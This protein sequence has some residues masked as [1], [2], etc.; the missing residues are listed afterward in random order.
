M[1]VTD[2][3]VI[4]YFMLSAGDPPLSGLAKKVFAANPAVIVPSLWRHEYLNVL[5]KYV[6]GRRLDLSAA[7]SLWRAALINFEPC[8]RPLRQERVLEIVLE[9]DVAG[10][11]AQYLALAEDFK[12]KVITE[13]KKLLKAAP[14]IC[15]SMAEWLSKT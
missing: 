11:D 8:E 9:K 13:D 3:N 2:V 15:L 12:A 7:E 14:E 6:R 5:A 1:I 4:V 10:F